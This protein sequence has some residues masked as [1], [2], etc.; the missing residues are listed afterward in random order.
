MTNIVTSEK[1]R[2]RVAIFLLA[3]I[4]SMIC[5]ASISTVDVHADDDETYTRDEVWGT[6]LKE[7]YRLARRIATPLAAMSFAYGGFMFFGLSIFS[8]KEQEKRMSQGRQ[9]MVISG[10]ALAAMYLLPA[11]YSLGKA[12]FSGLA[13]SPP[14]AG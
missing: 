4:C 7:T 6:K 12:T 1:F 13:Y 14:G 10:I 11:V 2:R 9:I 5:M 8:N 3:A